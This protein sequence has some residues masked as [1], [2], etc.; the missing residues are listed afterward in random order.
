[1]ERFGCQPFLDTYKKWMDA[2]AKVESAPSMAMMAF[3]ILMNGVGI[4]TRYFL[5]RPLLWVHE[6][7]ILIGT[8][9]FYVGTGLLYTR[10]EDISLDLIVNKMPERMRWM[11]EQVIHWM[12][13]IFLIIL[14]IASYKLIPFVSMSGSMLSFSLG[15]KDVYYY[16][17]V[18]VGSILMFIPVLYKTLKE[19]KLVNKKVCEVLMVS[20]YILGSFVLLMLFKMPIS[21]SMAISSLIGLLIAG[22]PLTTIPQWMAHGVHS[23]PLMAIPFFIF[24]GGLLNAA[25]LTN[26]IFNFANVF[27]SRLPGGLAQVAIIT[28]MIFSGISG[29][30]VAD[31]AALGPIEMKAMTERGYERNFSAAVIVSSTVLGPIIP[32]SIIFIIYAISAR[33]SIAKMFLAG[34]VPGLIIA[35][36]MMVWI[37]YVAV[38]G[39]EKCPPP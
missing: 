6:L 38:T 33:I 5:N 7:T 9:L 18:G 14:T 31:V 21:L 36:F 34:V 30:M 8:W 26:R 25:G 23:Y 15:I 29:S 32:P 28:E 17:P 13:L 20:I 39:K 3:L 35:A 1:M 4:F 22:V 11:T 10:K 24:A 37:Y 27:V 19:L 16:I 2:L 12:I